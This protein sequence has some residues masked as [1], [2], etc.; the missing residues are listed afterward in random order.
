MVPQSEWQRPTTQWTTQVWWKEEP[1]L[2]VGFKP[3]HSFGKS[4]RRGVTKAKNKSTIRP[5]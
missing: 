5:S 4:V 2:T 1:S 3:V